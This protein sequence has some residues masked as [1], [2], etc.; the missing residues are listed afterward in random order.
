MQSQQSGS[1]QLSEADR[2]Y[3]TMMYEEHGEHARQHENLRAV[4]GSLFITL[5]AGLLAFASDKWFVGLCVCVVSILG[6]LLNNVHYK[7]YSQHVDTMK[8]FRE[9][10]EKGVSPPLRE[11]RKPYDKGWLRLHT[12]WIVIY[13]ATFLLG[14]VVVIRGL[15]GV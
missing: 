5:V 13:V 1:G 3:L 8:A 15:I 9:E 14:L 11:I 2:Q 4:M 12:L 10:L 6:A 7:R